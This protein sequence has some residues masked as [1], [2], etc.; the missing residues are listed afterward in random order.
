MSVFAAVRNLPQFLSV[1]LLRVPPLPFLTSMCVMGEYGRQ[2]YFLVKRAVLRG[3]FVR[4]G[5]CS[6]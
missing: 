2:W 3:T 1:L 4:Q 6:G 5:R